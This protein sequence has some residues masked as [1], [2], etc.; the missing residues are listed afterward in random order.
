MGAKIGN[1][2]FSGMQ[3][4]QSK[5]G[6]GNTNNS[7]SWLLSCSRF[8]NDERRLGK[9]Y[10]ISQRIDDVM[11]AGRHDDYIFRILPFKKIPLEFLCNKPIRE[12]S[13]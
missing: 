1:R 12:I 11:C 8:N 5:R 6:N 10:Q 3:Q 2:E 13:K 7:F 4:Q 9:E